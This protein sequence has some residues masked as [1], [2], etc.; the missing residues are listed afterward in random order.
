MHARGAA[1]VLATGALTQIGKIGKALENVES[2]KTPLQKET[3]LVKKLAL[4]GLALCALVVVVFGIT[5]NDWLHGLLAG[6]TMAM[7]VLPEEFPVV[8]T[9]FLALGAWRISQNRVLTRR[10]PAVEMLGATT[11]LCTDKTGTLTENRMTVKKLFA[12][13][14]FWSLDGIMGALPDGIHEVVEYRISGLEKDPFDPMEKA[15]QKLGDDYLQKTKMFIETGVWCRSIHSRRSCWL[16]PASGG[17]RREA[18]LSLP[19]KG[20]PEAIADLC[21]LDEPSRQKLSENIVAMAEEGLRAP[22][23]SPE[24]DSKRPKLPQAQHDFDFLISGSRGP[25]RSGASR[26]CRCSH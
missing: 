5:R 8:L 4:V 20:A 18:I 17:H 25:C 6:I 26:H 12:A 22:Q 16:C 11:V 10:V 24:P 9:I 15:F 7:A 1:Q 14:Q 2:E 3:E 21:H 23:V 13:G 19:P